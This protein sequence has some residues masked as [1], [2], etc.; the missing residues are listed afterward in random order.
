MDQ[1]QNNDDNQDF[2]GTLAKTTDSSHDNTENTPQEEKKQ[3]ESE[4]NDQNSLS[5]LETVLTLAQKM[6]DTK[7][8]EIKNDIE[9]SFMVENEIS[10]NDFVEN[11][12]DTVQEQVL[13]QQNQEEPKT[14][15]NQNVAA[16]KATI[17]E[18]INSFSGKPYDPS[19]DSKTEIANENPTDQ[20]ATNVEPTTNEE[21]STKQNEELTKLELTELK[22]VDS[23]RSQGQMES[24]TSQKSSNSKIDDSKKKQKA[25]SNGNSRAFVT[26]NEQLSLKSK[27]NS[28]TSIPP[29]KT[30][31]QN[32]SRYT[33]YTFQQPEVE[34]TQEEIELAYDRLINNRKP[35]SE[36]MS[37]PLINYV[38]RKKI[39]ALVASDY[40]EAQKM[41]E[42]LSLICQGKSQHVKKKVIETRANDLNIRIGIMKNEYK[43]RADFWKDKMRQTKAEQD[44]KLEWLD[45]K[46]QKE[47]EEFKKQWQNPDYIR[48]FNRPSTRLLQF[49]HVEKKM[50]LQ[51]DYEGAKRTKAIADQLQRQEE[52]QMQAYIETKMKSDFTK[53]R[54]KQQSEINKMEQFYANIETEMKI[55]MQKELESIQNGIKALEVKKDSPMT[56]RQ[57]VHYRGATTTKTSPSAALTTVPTPRTQQ[58]FSLYRSGKTGELNLAP[59]DVEKLS[60]LPSG[61]LRKK[62][63]AESSMSSRFP[64]L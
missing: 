15:T 35:P 62:K 52:R 40:D 53:M 12:S 8:E 22:I 18:T 58:R 55:K 44:Q 29:I 34:Y 31:T 2:G 37:T 13:S 14:D 48:Q 4:K 26:D 64:K 19:S 20:Q 7:D 43:E 46:Q 6:L 45:S 1:E 50:A 3:S 47:V 32:S 27:G 61:S 63:R 36:E 30:S 24:A 57:Y 16:L 38:N 5:N 17:Q 42:A 23:T 9:Q 10:P 51:R 41:D 54:E 25:P 56:N 39:D 28:S 60:K 11:E 33:L 49:R 21:P 59:I